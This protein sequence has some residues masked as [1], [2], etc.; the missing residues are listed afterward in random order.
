V[1]CDEAMTLI[2]AYIDDELDFVRTLEMEAHLRE[3]AACSRTCAAYQ[4]L[5]RAIPP[6]APYF[7]ARAALR[8]RVFAAVAR[9]AGDEAGSRPQRGPL[10]SRWM[11]TAASLAIVAVALSITWFVLHR[12]PEQMTVHDVVASHVRSLIDGHVTDVSSS[13][14]HTVKPWFTGKLDYSPQVSDLSAQGFPLAGGRLDYLAGRPVA[15]L[16]YTRGKHVISVFTWPAGTR[17]Q[18]ALIESS[19]QGFNI[20]YAS[21][22]GMT[23]WIISD[24]NRQD[25]KQFAQLLLGRQRP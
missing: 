9:A 18:A 22:S 25:L 7:R 3:C 23:Y 6:G 16:V 2:H 14:Q 1:R 12:A 17:S 13:D 8:E 20:L 5:R 4:G 10:R 15:A 24:L 11:E 19:R 21:P